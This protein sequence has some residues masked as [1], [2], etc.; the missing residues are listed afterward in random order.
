MATFKVVLDTRTKRRDGNYDLTVRVSHQKKVMYLKIAQLNE[1]Q[2]QHI[3]LKKSLDKKSTDFREKC[4]SY[5]SKCERLFTQIQPFNGERFRK[6]FFE[7]EKKIPVTLLLSDLFNY[8]IEN[9]RGI[10]RRSREQ[11]RNS[12]HVFD[13]YHP[14]VTVHNI[15]KGFLNQFE[16]DMVKSKQLSSV[17]VQTH[18]RNLRR[19][20]NY[21]ILEVKLIPSS[22]QY[23]FGKGGYS[24]KNSFPRKLVLKNEEIQNV[25]N[26]NDFESPFQEYSRDVWVFLYRS[27]GVNFADALRWRW[28]DIKGDYL[29]FT[30]KK[31]ENTRKNNV[32]QGIVP[33]TE[34]VKESLLKVGKKDSPFILGLL[35]EGYTED[36]FENRS[37]KIR[38]KINRELT[39]ITQKL[40]L[41]VPLKLKTARDTYATSL[42]RAGVSKDEIGEMLVHANSIVTEHYLD[43]LDSEKTFEINKHIL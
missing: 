31:T 30:R 15:T 19:I 4:N 36:T 24:I 20:L 29:F 26:L 10:K 38:Q 27:S 11:Y 6:L 22:Y 13:K 41:S 7:E 17:S 14:G 12:K 18:C 1:H 28:D 33:L 35:K 43:A 25:I 5:I 39:K 16:D 8:Y 23:P 21:F 34:G 32:K 37:H 42:K 3:F 9:Y 2:Y 40:N